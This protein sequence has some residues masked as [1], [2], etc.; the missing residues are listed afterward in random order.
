MSAYVTWRLDPALSSA[1]SFPP[2]VAE[3]AQARSTL[4]Q[5]ARKRRRS[6][7]GSARTSEKDCS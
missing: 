1:R 6:A 5:T 4:E 3:L 7:G 2:V